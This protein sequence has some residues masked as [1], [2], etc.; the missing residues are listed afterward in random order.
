MTRDEV[1][2]E[3]RRLAGEGYDIIPYDDPLEP[4]Q[5]FCCIRPIDD[6]GSHHEIFLK[7]LLFGE[8][9]KPEFKG[10]ILPQEFLDLHGQDNI[11][12]AD[13]PKALLLGVVQY[14]PEEKRCEIS[15]VRLR[16]FKGWPKDI[17]D[18]I[19]TVR[20]PHHARSAARLKE[21]ADLVAD[22]Q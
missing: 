17:R 4:S 20:A 15:Q 22:A 6:I 21:V 12:L 10:D 2:A 3:A 13:D 5:G 16:E 7:W 11:A 8:V 18:Q 9:L 1:L 19:D 14:F